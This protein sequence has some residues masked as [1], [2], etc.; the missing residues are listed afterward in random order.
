[1][2][3]LKDEICCKIS[4]YLNIYLLNMDTT[5]SPYGPMTAE[6]ILS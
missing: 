1:M 2:I 3:V 6:D 5:Q 4:K